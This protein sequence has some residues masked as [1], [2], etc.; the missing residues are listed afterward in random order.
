MSLR[1]CHCTSTLQFSVKG[2]LLFRPYAPNRY[3]SAPLMCAV[4]LERL[5][6]NCAG[7]V[8]TVGAVVPNGLSKA[9]VQV[10]NT[11]CTKG[12]CSVTPK[13]PLNPPPALGENSVKNSPRS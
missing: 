8:L 2:S 7:L 11:G 3:G 13:G 1:G 6:M 9:M 5:L 10:A 4:I 12:G